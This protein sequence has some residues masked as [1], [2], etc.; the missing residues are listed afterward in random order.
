MPRIKKDAVP[1]SIRLDRNVSQ[2]LDNFIKD[3][4]QSKTT[5]V[6]RALQLYM[7]E[8]YK[9]QSIIESRS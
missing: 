1:F 2:Q 9:G 7:S 4:G 6:E 8:Y 5:A 3:S